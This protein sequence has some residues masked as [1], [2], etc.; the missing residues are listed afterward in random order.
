[1]DLGGRVYLLGSDQTPCAG[2]PNASQGIGQ[3]VVWWIDT[4]D[5]LGSPSAA[6][7]DRL[8]IK[9]E[10]VRRW[11]LGDGFMFLAVLPA[12]R[13]GHGLSLLLYDRKGRQPWFLALPRC[14]TV[15]PR[16][17]VLIGAP[18]GVRRG[19][20]NEGQAVVSQTGCLACHQIGSD[21]NNGPG[22]KLTRI[23]ARLGAAQLQRALIDP[24]APMPSFRELKRQHPKQFAALLY[25][26]RE[27]K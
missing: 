16:T 6:G 7:S 27:L 15:T 2:G 23:G 4:K 26:L 19:E 10:R 8:I 20:F 22:P 3:D 14:T 24:R 12:S 13:C 9:G 25:F 18:A 21:G 5:A 17:P 11:T 1:L